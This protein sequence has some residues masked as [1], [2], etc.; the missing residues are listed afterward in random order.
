MPLPGN[1]KPDG[2]FIALVKYSEPTIRIEPMT[3]SLPRKCSTTELR[4]HLPQYTFPLV[5]E[6]RVPPMLHSALERETGLEP[7]TLSLEG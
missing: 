5:T 2:L 6:S 3:S 7:A 1:L 4:G